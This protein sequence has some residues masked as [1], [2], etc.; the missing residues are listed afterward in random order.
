METLTRNGS[1]RDRVALWRKA[2]ERVAL[3]PT[4][5]TLHKGHLRLVAEAQERA[6]RV[7]VSVFAAAAGRDAP[8]SGTDRDLLKNVGADLVFA[9]PIQEMYPL[10][11]DACTSVAAPLD[12][13]LPGAMLA[14]AEIGT[15]LTLLLKLLHVVAPDIAVFGERD[16]VQLIAVRRMVADLFVPVEIVSCET[17]RETDGLALASSNRL[18]GAEQ[19]RIAPGL[20][21]GLREI[22]R[23]I[24]A[25]ARDY[26]S[27]E[28]QG[29]ATL[30]QAGLEPDY[31]AIRAALDLSLVHSKTRDLVLLAGAKLGTMRIIDNLRVRLVDRY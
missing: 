4:A 7:V 28:E 16:F 18:L 3:L 10:G 13:P 19:R 20:H 31:F 11:T 27:L 8:L 9:P 30:A 17:L 24:D 1:V 22:G 2:G 21:A 26:A 5:G 6:E 23:L 25:G 14:P 15:G 12:V 29:L